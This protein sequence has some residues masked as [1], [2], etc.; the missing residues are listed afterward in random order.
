[1][2]STLK[3]TIFG[4]ETTSA[5]A[6]FLCVSSILAELEFGDVGFR[7]GWKTEEPREKPSKQ[8]ENQQQTQSP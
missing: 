1:M 8:G 6:G 2:S 5:L 4:Q 7:I 3:I